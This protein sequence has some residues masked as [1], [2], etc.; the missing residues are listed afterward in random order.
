MSSSFWIVVWVM[1]LCVSCRQLPSY[2]RNILSSLFW[3]GGGEGYPVE[4]RGGTGF[5]EHFLWFLSVPAGECWA[6][7]IQGVPGGKDLT[8]GECSLGQAIP[9]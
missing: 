4:A 7:S 9:I 5:V 6:S 2:L 3:T 8:S 1:G